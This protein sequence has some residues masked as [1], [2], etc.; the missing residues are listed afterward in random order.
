MNRRVARVRVTTSI[1][2]Q[3]ISVMGMNVGMKDMNQGFGPTR[4][5]QAN[6]SSRTSGHVVMYGTNAV[7]QLP[8][9]T[10]LMAGGSPLVDPLVRRDFTPHLPIAEVPLDITGS[11]ESVC[12]GRKGGLLLRAHQHE[13]ERPGVPIYGHMVGLQGIHQGLILDREEEEVGST[14]MEAHT[15]WHLLWA[16]CPCQVDPGVAYDLGGPDL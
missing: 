15:E 4:I 8:L 14:Q 10:K 1:P 5:P 6:C 13:P 2:S 11:R 16:G 12:Q 9:P 3:D 7:D